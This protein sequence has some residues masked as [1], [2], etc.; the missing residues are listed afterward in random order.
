MIADA[1]IAR[2]FVQFGQDGP[3]LGKAGGGWLVGPGIDLGAMRG[4][5]RRLVSPGPDRIDGSPHPG[6]AVGAAV[7]AS[8]LA[9]GWPRR[10]PGSA[11]VHVAPGG[12]GRPAPGI[13]H[14]AFRRNRACRLTVAPAGSPW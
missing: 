11:T 14:Q 5:P 2:G 12:H 1:L 13:R 8:L 3:Q 10:A 6:G 4:Q 7:F 9:N